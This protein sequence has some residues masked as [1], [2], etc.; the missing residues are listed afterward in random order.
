MA[1]HAV[2]IV[3][4]I[5][6]VAV[7]NEH[8]LAV[9]DVGDASRQVLRSGESGHESAK[10]HCDAQL[11]NES[12][13]FS[14]MVRIGRAHFG[15]RFSTLAQSRWRSETARHKATRALL[16]GRGFDLNL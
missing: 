4:R 16:V 9:A 5:A 2:G 8:A 14:T 6:D 11:E 12:S 1:H 3:G 15:L 13:I 10:Q 7:L